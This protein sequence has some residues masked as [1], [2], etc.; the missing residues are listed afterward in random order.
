MK[1]LNHANKTEIGQQIRSPYGRFSTQ[2]DIYGN[3]GRVLSKPGKTDAGQTYDPQVNQ[4]HCA[5]PIGPIE[6]A[7]NWGFESI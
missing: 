7:T 2:E 3:Q 4:D 6:L 5:Q 1:C